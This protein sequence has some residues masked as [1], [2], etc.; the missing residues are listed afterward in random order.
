MITWNYIYSRLSADE[1]LAHLEDL[2][3]GD[4]YLGFLED[5]EIT[6]EDNDKSDEES[7]RNPLGRKAL[8]VPSLSIFP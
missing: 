5:D 7:Q 3:S 4:I 2:E 1:A 8:E 6:D